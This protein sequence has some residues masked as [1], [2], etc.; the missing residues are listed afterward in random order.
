MSGGDYGI[1]C[2]FANGLDEMK[3]VVKNTFLMTG[4]LLK[5][6]TLSPSDVKN[7]RSVSLPPFLFN[8]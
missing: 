1:M 2:N 5:K 7:Y 8:T 3:T 6:P 4:F